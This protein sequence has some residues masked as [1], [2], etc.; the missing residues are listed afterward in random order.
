MEYYSAIKKN[1]FESILMRWM[2]LEPIIQSEV[3]QKDKDQYSTLMHIYG[4]YGSFCSPRGLLQLEHCG[5]CVTVLRLLFQSCVSTHTG[6]HMA[7]G[8]ERGLDWWGKSYQVVRTEVHKIRPEQNLPAMLLTASLIHALILLQ[9]DS[10]WSPGYWGS[11]KQ[12]DMIP[13]VRSPSLIRELW[14]PAA[15]WSQ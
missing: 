3:S 9:T 12:S 15:K 7:K 10:F 2:I 1:S 6:E 13:A 4:M 11:L 14:M 8:Q 5:L